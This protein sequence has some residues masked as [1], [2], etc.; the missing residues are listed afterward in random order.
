MLL[1]WRMG[2]LCSLGTTITGWLD[3]GG[4]ELPQLPDSEYQSPPS[5]SRH[6]DTKTVTCEE[7][8]EVSATRDTQAI[9]C[10]PATVSTWKHCFDLRDLIDENSA[11]GVPSTYSVASVI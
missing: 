2:L 8:L 9:P 3:E 5:K 1:F 6:S 11:A 4:S 7:G 10:R